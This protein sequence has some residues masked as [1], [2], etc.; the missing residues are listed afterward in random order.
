MTVIDAKKTYKNLIKKGFIDAVNKSPD[1]KWLEFYHN[2]ELILSTK[3]S[4]GEKDLNDFLIKQMSM[5]CK[6]NKD[7][8]KNLALCP[9]SYEQYVDILKQK[10][11]IT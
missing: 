5:Q 9:L 6:L 4:H 7:D 1:H 2:E 11:F 3:I 8:F 10:G